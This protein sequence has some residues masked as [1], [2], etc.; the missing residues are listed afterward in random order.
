MQLKYELFK[1]LVQESRTIRRFQAQKPISRDV[2]LELVGLARLTPSAGNLQPL[3]YILVNDPEVKAELFAQ[4]KW[5]RDLPDWGGP[6]IS[7]RPAAYIVIL[8]DNEIRDAFGCD[9]GIAAQT[10]MLGARAM[11]LGCCMLGSVNRPY[12]QQLWNLEKRYDILL[13]LALGEPAE[14][15]VIEEM[16]SGESTKYWRSE[17][18][19]HH[20]PKRPVSELIL[21]EYT[22]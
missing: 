20:V 16:R 8:A 6:A 9:H 12:L 18:E 17:D 7:E 21:K 19:V 1:N 3:K 14:T 22:I 13:V 4:V 11:G 5:A 10:I 2:L 15:V